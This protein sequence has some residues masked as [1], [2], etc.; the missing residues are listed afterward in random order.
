MIE[1]F[2]PELLLALII[3]PFMISILITIVIITVTVY[4]YLTKR[5]RRLEEMNSSNRNFTLSQGKEVNKK[6]KTDPE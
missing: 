6:S 4:F 2:S 3:S 1:N 5:N